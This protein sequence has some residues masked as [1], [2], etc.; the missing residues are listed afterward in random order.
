MKLKHKTSSEIKYIVKCRGF[1]DK[2][3][4]PLDFKQF[5][6]K[7]I[8]DLFKKLFQKMVEAYGDEQ[9]NVLLERTHFQPS[10]RQGQVTSRSQKRYLNLNIKK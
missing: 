1:W 4:S 7:F 10:W 9:D 8:L 6:V 3:D 2:V 5:Q